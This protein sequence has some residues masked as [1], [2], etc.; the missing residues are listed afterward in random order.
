MRGFF[1][2]DIKSAYFNLNAFLKEVHTF[3]DQQIKMRETQDVTLICKPPEGSD[4]IKLY[5]DKSRLQQILNNLLSN[6]VKFTLKG[7]IEFGYIVKKEEGK[8]FFQFYVKDSGIGIPQD[9]QELI[10][11]SFRQADDTI[12]KKFGGTGLGL[13]I[14]RKIVDL[15]GGRIWVESEAGKGT[16]F[17]FKIPRADMYE[18]K[19]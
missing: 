11:E 15:F 18:T 17:Y 12:V 14:S 8:D 10:F 16:T 2:F 7:T 3:F 6:A 4:Q 5:S 9:K 1:I 19:A 13:A